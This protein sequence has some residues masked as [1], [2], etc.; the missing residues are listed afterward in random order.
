MS[1]TIASRLWK[2]A[3]GDEWKNGV[4]TDSTEIGKLLQGA[5][6][7]LLQTVSR[8]PLAETFAELEATWKAETMFVSSATEM[9][10]HPAYQRIVGMGPVAVPLIL[11]SLRSSPEHWFVALAAITGADPVPEVERGDVDRMAETW[12]RWGR[13]RRL[14]S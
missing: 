1:T 3:P 6:Q 8:Q 4:S 11:A 5:R 9:C 12:L 10:S 7:H 2:S 13:E 14:V